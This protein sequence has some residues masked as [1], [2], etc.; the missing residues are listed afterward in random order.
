MKARDDNF[1]INNFYA[2]IEEIHSDNL[3]QER[4]MELMNLYGDENES[5]Y[6][7]SII[8]PDAKQ[9]LITDYFSKK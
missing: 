8:I 5:I 6:F 3:Y 4:S 1:L 9:Q 7:N 2:W